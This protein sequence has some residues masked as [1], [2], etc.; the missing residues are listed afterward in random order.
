[1][2]AGLGNSFS[3]WPTV[4][5]FVVEAYAMQILSEFT[6]NDYLSIEANAGFKLYIEES[7]YLMAGYAAGIPAS[8]ERADNPGYGMMSMA[9]R[10]FL[11]F[12]YEPS[13]GD[14]DRDGIKDDVDQ[15]PTNPE[16]K[17][18]YL[19][20]DGC[21]EPDNDL[22]G[23]PDYRDKCPLVPEDLD[24]SE[25]RDGCPERDAEDRDGDGIPDNRDRCPDNP[26]DLDGFEDADGCP[27]PDND[28]DGIL[29]VND[30]CPDDPEDMDGYQDTDGCPDPDNDGDRILDI[31]DRCPD[32]AEVYNGKDDDDG[33]P[34]QGDV[35]LQGDSIQ[36]LKKVYFEY[37]SANIKNVSYD[38]LDAVAQ[39]IINNPQINL[40]EV[41]GHA[42]ENGSAD[43]NLK[44]TTDRA[45]SVMR[46][47]LG[48][49][50]PEKALTSMGYGEYCPIEEGRGE[51]VWEKNRRVEFKVLV[52]DGRPTGARRGC[53]LAEQAGVTPAT[54]ETQPATSPEGESPASP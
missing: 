43:Y 48:K 11:G 6:N 28:Q 12:A 54:T 20:S 9:H 29:D 13:I 25:D 42:D 32:N 46:Y 16:D 21:P 23:I 2:T 40:V 49:G 22:D 44:L 3:I 4:M 33:C 37:D 31:N 8:G 7:S 18:D 51:A 41:A 47:L 52:S 24:G 39:T 10:M 14:R 35:I 19:D 34:D 45:A 30:N 17:D 15:C 36:I 27:D 53:D 38:I 5:D 50:V 26:E 1:M